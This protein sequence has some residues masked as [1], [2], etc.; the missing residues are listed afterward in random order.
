MDLLCSKG[1]GAA[2]CRCTLQGPHRDDPS[3]PLGDAGQCDLPKFLCWQCHPGMS[4]PLCQKEGRRTQTSGVQGD[5][6]MVF[7]GK[8][9][10]IQHP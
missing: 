3:A 6:C 9:E 1:P 7:S 10:P 2:A 4:L 8:S 5:S